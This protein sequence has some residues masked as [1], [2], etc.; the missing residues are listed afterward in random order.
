MADP[1]TIDG[2]HLVDWWTSGSPGSPTRIYSDAGSTL[3]NADAQAIQ[4]WIGVNGNALSQTT[5]ANKPKWDNVLGVVQAEYA[6]NEW[7]AP[8]S[9]I[10]V[11]NQSCTLVFVVDLVTLRYGYDGSSNQGFHF[12]MEA[13]SDGDNPYYPRG[14]PLAVYDGSFQLIGP[15]P[16]LHTST[17]F[18][19]FSQ[20]S[21]TTTAYINSS[22]GSHAVAA[23]TGNI[24]ALLS[25]SSASDPL[26][27]AVRDIVLFNAAES[28]GNVAALYAWA[29]SRGV[30][31]SYNGN[32]V[33][34]GDS[35]TAG[36]GNTLNRNWFRQLTL[37]GTTRRANT[38]EAGITLATLV[39]EASTFVDP[40]IQSGGMTNALGVFA[41]TNDLVGGA[42]AATVYANTKTYCA[43]RKTAGW[44]PVFII[45]MLPRTGQETAR[46]ALR[47]DLLGDFTVSTS[48]PLVYAAGAGT[49]YADYYLDIAGDANIGAANANTNATYYAADQI[50]LNN[51]GSGV[52]TGYAQSLI[53]KVL[54][55]ASPPATS[56]GSV[57]LAIGCGLGIGLLKDEVDNKRKKRRRK[58]WNWFC[59]SLLLILPSIVHGATTQPADDAPAIAAQLTVGPTTLQR[60]RVYNVSQIKLTAVPVS[61]T[62][63]ASTTVKALPSLTV[64]NSTGDM[65]QLVNCYSVYING[66]GTIDQNRA[67]RGTSAD[68]HAIRFMGCQ[69]ILVK[70]VGFRDAPLDAIRFATSNQTAPAAATMYARVTQCRFDRCYRNQI[71]VAEGSWISIDNNSFDNIG[72]DGKGGGPGTGSPNGPWAATDIE[73]LTTDPKGV[74]HHIFIERNTVDHAWWGFVTNNGLLCG[75]HDVTFAQNQTTAAVKYGLGADCLKVTIRDNH[76]AT[77]ISVG[78]GADDCYIICNLAGYIYCD[79]HGVTNPIGQRVFG[80]TVPAPGL[81]DVHQC[82]GYVTLDGNIGKVQQ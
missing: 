27:A 31:S 30:S 63:P 9:A 77:W 52:L 4:Q 29:Q 39:S 26:C 46:Q 25:A 49:T 75:T 40:Q 71:T 54:P 8:L 58:I 50:H 34:D 67:Q 44:G 1:T 33:L 19:C 76:T 7:I 16:L 38:S 17:V 70:G 65:F 21:G 47:T 43:A 41:A 10:S 62:I 11:N 20:A 36:A 61:L 13:A 81:I 22:S 80:N 42:T 14:G 69:H 55:S 68:V 53:Y 15:P 66:G 72:I 60:G 45:G 35:E 79:V 18:I 64:A 51:T 48:M 73:P 56:G 59:L 5:S 6:A 74:T 3:V 78:S 24:A 28:A 37:S 57:G 23:H 12:F 2:A 82:L 32:L